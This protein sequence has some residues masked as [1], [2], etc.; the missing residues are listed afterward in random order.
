VDEN[1][2]IDRL[3]YMAAN[4]PVDVNKVLFTQAADEIERLR[5]ALDIECQAKEEEIERLRAVL[6]A[7]ADYRPGKAASSTFWATA[8]GKVLAIRALLNAAGK[9]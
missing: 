6:R 8:Y 9:D 2:T 5:K 4:D 7:L 3:R 1:T